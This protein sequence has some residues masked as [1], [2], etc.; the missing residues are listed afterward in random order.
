MSFPESERD[1]IKDAGWDLSEE[2][3]AKPDFMFDLLSSAS[4]ADIRKVCNTESQEIKEM[5]HVLRFSV[6]KLKNF[7][8]KE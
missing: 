7:H 2:L 3:L 8:D 5:M 1:A 4:D 6:K